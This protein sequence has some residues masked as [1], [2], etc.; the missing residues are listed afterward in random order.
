M[1]IMLEMNKVCQEMREYDALRREIE[2]LQEETRRYQAQKGHENV[3]EKSI[4]SRH[5]RHR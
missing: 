1:R 4:A 5:Y 2:S 3:K